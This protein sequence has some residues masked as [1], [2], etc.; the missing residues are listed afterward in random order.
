MTATDEG[1]R[2][3]AGCGARLAV[4]EVRGRALPACPACGAVVWPDPK[5][6]VGAAVVDAGRLLLV[7]RALQPGR[8]LWSVPGGFLD[9]GEEPGD[10]AAREA[11]EE[12]GL[13]VET[14]A[15]LGAYGRGD[16]GRADV[17]L[18]YAGRPVGGVLAPGD[19]ADR[20]GWFGPDGLPPLVFGSTL[21][22]VRHLR[23][24]PL[25]GR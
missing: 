20:V 7:R 23:G 21:D 8:G 14:G 1:P 9:A 19:D 25:L 3:C 6:A 17:F 22:A 16:G 2:H 11:L 4:R 13:V 24:E 10:V 18:L 5:V 12:T 15:L